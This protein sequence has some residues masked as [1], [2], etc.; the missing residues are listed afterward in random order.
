MSRLK[1]KIAV[2]PAHSASLRAYVDRRH[3]AGNACENDVAVCLFLLEI[4]RA[5]DEAVVAGRRLEVRRLSRQLRELR[6]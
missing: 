1:V 3:A 6:P 2:T 4:A 5:I